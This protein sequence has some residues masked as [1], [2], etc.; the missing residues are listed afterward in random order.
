MAGR[1][2]SPA[3][4]AL[5]E[6]G[7]RVLQV[8]EQ[9]AGRGSAEVSLDCFMDATGLCR[10]SVRHAIKLIERLGF[11]AISTEHRRVNQFALSGH[12]R[13]LDEVEARRRI[14]M[15]RLPTPPRQTS[16][17]PRAARPVK[18]VHP[19]EQS[20]PPRQPSMPVVAWLGDGR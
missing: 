7:R 5:S 12:W 9:R 8:I 2:Q 17:P 19:V 11:I 4:L 15:A 10:S 14:A 13:E 3:Y 16:A 1:S 20:P 6:G 18:A